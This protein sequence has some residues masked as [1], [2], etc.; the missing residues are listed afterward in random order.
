MASPSSA[1]SLCCQ[2]LHPQV[3][4]E[5]DPESFTIGAIS[6]GGATP[7][8]SPQ[9][10]LLQTFL[11]Y[12]MASWAAMEQLGGQVAEGCQRTTWR[13]TAKRRRRQ[14]FFGYVPP[15]LRQGAVLGLF[16]IY[17]WWRSHGSSAIF[18]TSGREHPRATGPRL[19]W[20]HPCHLSPEASVVPP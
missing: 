10:T 16:I 17:W 20:Q 19:A 15:I 7:G 2:S 11:S 6:T 5:N 1:A 4:P 12:V 18:V 13:S 14:T 8:K 9:Q 3:S